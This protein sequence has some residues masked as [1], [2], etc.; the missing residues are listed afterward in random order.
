VVDFSVDGTTFT[1]T[2]AMDGGVK[3]VVTGSLPVAITA[4]R[5]LNTPRYAKLPA[6]MKAK[7][8]P[9]AKLGLGDLGLS[10]DAVASNATYSNYAPPAPRP[11]GRILEGDLDTQIS[12]LV[13]LLREEAKVI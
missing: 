9:V 3:Q 8:K 11:A 4:E 1:A 2:R 7:K 12:E 6:I 13:R 10:A 5:G